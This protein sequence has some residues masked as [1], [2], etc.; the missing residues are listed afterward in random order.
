MS[1]IALKPLHVV[2]QLAHW[3]GCLLGAGIVALFTAFAIGEGLPPLHALNFSFA[4]I[5]VMLGGFVLM[6]WK[7]WLGGIL[8]LAGLA[9]FQAIELLV[10][11]QMSR[12]LIP[13][14]AVPGIIAVAAGIARYIAA[15]QARRHDHQQAH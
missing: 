7:D 4:A 9:W 3:S 13:L 12:G 14:F 1:T 15:A 5:G 8:S 10:N 11:G 2:A 6:W